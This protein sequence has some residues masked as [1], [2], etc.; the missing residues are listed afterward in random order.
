MLVEGIAKEVEDLPRNFLLNNWLPMLKPD[1]N[2]RQEY[3]LIGIW[4]QTIACKYKQWSFSLNSQ[5]GKR[6]VTMVIDENVKSPPTFASGWFNRLS[7]H[8]FVHGLQ[9]KFTLLQIKSIH[10]S[11]PPLP[12]RM[13]TALC[14]RTIKLNNNNS[15]VLL[16]TVLVSKLKVIS[17]SCIWNLSR[18]LWG[19]ANISIIAIVINNLMNFW[20]E[21]VNSL[22]LIQLVIYF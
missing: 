8:D 6:I 10:P 16:W 9:S 13:D 14:L 7:I 5:I 11:S 19:Y 2:C 4:G 22:I 1:W 15:I 18:N 20:N 3:W 12:P 21:T 17:T